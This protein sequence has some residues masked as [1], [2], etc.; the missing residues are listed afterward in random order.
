MMNGGRSGGSGVPGPTGRDLDALTEHDAEI[1]GGDDDSDFASDEDDDAHF[2]TAPVRRPGAANG[3]PNG[4]INGG[5]VNSDF[6]SVEK[7]LKVDLGNGDRDAGG[8]KKKR[9]KKEKEQEPGRLQNGVLLDPENLAE[10]P[11]D[12]GKKKKKEKKEKKE[13]K[14]KKKKDD[15]ND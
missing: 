7:E 15:Q 1:G 5:F 14:K 11:E 10:E 3:G 4:F 2:F 8:K 12:K 6:Y 13:K 9:K